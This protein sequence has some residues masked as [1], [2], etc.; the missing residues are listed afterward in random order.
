MASPFTV[1]FSMREPPAEA[2]A[3][4][5]DAFGEPARAVGLRLTGRGAGELQYG[6]RVQWPFLLMLW[7]KL[8]GV[9]M[10]VRF[11][12]G[13]AGGT[14]VKIN[15]AVTRDK[16]PLATDEEHWMEALGE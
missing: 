8:S 16:Q 3:R 10:A 13:D 11:A 9:K 12:E 1:E 5:A 15:G 7:H 2:Q 4:V 6:P 14:R